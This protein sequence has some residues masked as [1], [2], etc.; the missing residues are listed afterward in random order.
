MPQ[1]GD[2]I[3]RGDHKYSWDSA[4]KKYKLVR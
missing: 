4:S 1:E 3:E 2:I